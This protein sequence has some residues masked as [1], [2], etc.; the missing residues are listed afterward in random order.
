M[1]NSFKPILSPKV[2]LHN[3]QLGEYITVVRSYLYEQNL[4]PLADRL[5]SIEAN[6]KRM[7]AFMLKGV[8]DEQR[9]HIY[10]Q[11]LRK[12]YELSVEAKIAAEYKKNIFYSVAQS[13]AVVLDLSLS[14][15]K[16]TCQRYVQDIS[17]SQ[18]EIRDRKSVV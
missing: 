17:I 14:N 2:L 13:H 9:V 11:L 5:D 12:V 18:L 4:T 16:E 15:I 3:R 8:E 6:Y 10:N 1:P 7:Q